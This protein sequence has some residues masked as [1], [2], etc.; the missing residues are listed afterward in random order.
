MSG[1][2]GQIMQ[3]DA[4]IDTGAEGLFLTPELAA[5]LRPLG[6]GQAA[7]LVGVCGQQQVWRQRLM[8]IGIGPQSPPMQTHEAILTTNPVFALLGVE[9][10]VGQELLRIRGQLWRLDT[11][12]PRLELW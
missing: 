3:R 8:G 9:A 5:L 7:R 10:I 6:T 2:D 12:P 1:S 11:D 4:L